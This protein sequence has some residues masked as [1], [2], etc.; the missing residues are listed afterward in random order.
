MPK[1]DSVFRAIREERAD[2]AMSHNGM[3]KIAEVTGPQT[4]PWA[5]GSN[6]VPVID[7]YHSWW[8]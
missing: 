6:P 2:V 3:I 8:G 1:A 7:A 5:K 4:W